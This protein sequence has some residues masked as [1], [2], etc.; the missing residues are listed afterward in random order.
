M[1]LNPAVD[2]AV[3]V[4]TV[5]TGPDG[6]VLTSAT[7]PERKSFTLYSSVNTLHSVDSA[8]SGKYTCT[9]SVEQGVGVSASTNM[10]IGNNILAVFVQFT[11]CNFI[12]IVDG[13]FQLRLMSADICQTWYS[14]V[15]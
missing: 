12:S 5:W 10:T 6:A 9:V 15:S 1:E 2:V 13:L 7:Q 11:P 8:G 3:T 4:N 14:E